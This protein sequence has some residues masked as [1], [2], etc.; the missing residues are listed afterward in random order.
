MV[1]LPISKT[2][3]PTGFLP[4][5]IFIMTDLPDGA[6]I[7]PAQGREI[8]SLVVLL[9]GFG[10][11]G[12]DLISLASEWQPLMPNTAFYSPHACEPCDMGMGPMSGQY[13]WFSM[14]DRSEAHLNAGAQAAAKT[15]NNWLDTF[16]THFG[17]DESRTALV[18]FSQGC[19]MSLQVAPRRAPSFSCVLGYSGALP[20]AQSLGTELRCRPPTFLIHGSDD[21]VVSVYAMHQAEA[22]LNRQNIAVTSH[23]CSGLGHS[24]DSVGVAIGGQFLQTM[25]SR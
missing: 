2:T 7:L 9:H 13:Q 15:L 5:R 20:N 6:Q 21:D 19:M 23:I 11:N 12:D 10:S 24:I 18:G 17:V 25:L 4:N 3:A 22:E 1:A 16:M 14:T 8:Q